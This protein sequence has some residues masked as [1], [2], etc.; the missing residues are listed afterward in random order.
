MARL[1]RGVCAS[2]RDEFPTE[3]ELIALLREPY[4]ITPLFAVDPSSLGF[5]P[6]CPAKPEYVLGA[7]LFS[8]STA[9]LP[10]GETLHS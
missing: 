1:K 5:Y 4:P 9:H 2:S 6:L 8:R 3:I 7:P 10:N